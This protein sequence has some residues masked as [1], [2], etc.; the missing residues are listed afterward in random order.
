MPI[1]PLTRLSG[2]VMVCCPSITAQVPGKQDHWQEKGRLQASCSLWN[3]H[4]KYMG[5]NKECL[6]MLPSTKENK[7]T[8]TP[9]KY[10]SHSSAEALP[11]LI[12]L[13]DILALSGTGGK[14]YEDRRRKKMVQ[15]ECSVFALL[16]F[17]MIG[18]PSC[19]WG[20]W[21]IISKLMSSAEIWTWMSAGSC[22]S[23]HWYPTHGF[24][25]PGETWHCTARQSLCSGL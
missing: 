12:S 8:S 7:N 25:C 22:R 4:S 23:S 17:K 10:A 3:T 1:L 5:E 2:S 9:I 21:A 11:C 15:K 24:G 14:G 13:D 20:L 16:G 18:M 19:W 6:V